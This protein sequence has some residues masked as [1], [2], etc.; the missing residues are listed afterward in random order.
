MI[1]RL[2]P[3]L[4]LQ[5]G[6]FLCSATLVWSL[7]SLSL[8][9]ETTNTTTVAKSTDLASKA[10]ALTRQVINEEF[11]QSHKTELS[12]WIN[13]LPGMEALF[14]GIPRWQYAASLLY[15]VLAVSVSRALDWLIRNRLK[16][17]ASKTD[18]EWDDILV[19]LAEGPVKAITLVFLIHIGLEL[20]NWPLWLEINISRLSLIV[21]AVALTFIALRVI[22]L[23]IAAW[24]RQPKQG[25]DVAFNDQFVLLIGKLLKAVLILIT[26][27][28]LL[29][30]LGVDITAILGSVSVLGL[31]FGLAAQDS[32][33]NLFGA[34]AVFVDKPFKVG[35]R[36]K[37]GSDVDGVVEAMGLRATKVRNA[38]GFLITLPNK[39]V[40]NNTVINVSARPS[41][42]TVLNYGLTYDTPA[43]R[44]D[45]A[46]NLLR[47]IFTAHSLTGECQVTFN[48][49]D[50]SALNIEVN[51]QCLTRDLPT[52]QATLHGLNLEVKE[53]FDAEK[54]EFAFPTQTVFLK[55]D[56]SVP[57]N[58]SV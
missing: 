31:A 17:W 25:G 18:T 35:D 58:S 53:R 22:D 41:I 8:A 36:I 14:L 28:T 11:I 21:G 6:M 45:F 50:A 43:Q 51:Y 12:F 3:R 29:G 46:A 4:L 39:S 2:Q 15:L 47:S 27:L 54:L 38:D 30:N 10:S 42:R 52:Y 20:Y 7:W 44:I 26:S 48:R 9:A 23:A 37:V 32:V 55:K 13:Q 57:A 56:T 40:G 49:F 19:K 34:V 5:L 24:R 33:A 1:R 16:H